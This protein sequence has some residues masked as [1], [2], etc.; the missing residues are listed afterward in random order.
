LYH[1]SFLKQKIAPQSRKARR[2]N[3]W[4]QAGVFFFNPA[5]HRIEEK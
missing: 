2:V 4:Q 3:I 5:S 1:F